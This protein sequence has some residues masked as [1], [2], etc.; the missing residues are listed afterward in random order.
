MKSYTVTP[1]RQ[2]K[3]LDVNLNQKVTVS[4]AVVRLL[5]PSAALSE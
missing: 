1:P 3:H 2:P 5:T 4:A